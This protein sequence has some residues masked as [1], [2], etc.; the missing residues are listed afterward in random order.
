MNFPEERAVVSPLS[1]LPLIENFIMMNTTKKRQSSSTASL[2]LEALEDRMMLSSVEIFAAGET[3]NEAFNLL[4]DGN[5]VQTFDSVGGNFEAR[6]FERFVFNAD[7][8]VTA[9]RVEIEFINDQFNRNTG[10]DNNLFVDRIVVDGQTFEAEDSETFHTGLID[11]GRFVG[12]GFLQSEVLN[13]NGRISFLANQTRSFGTR[14]RVDA[15]GDT[16]EEI[17]Q[18]QIDGRAVADFNFAAAG[19]EQVLLF[20]TDEIV[21]ISRV[22]LV[23]TND[24]FDPRTGLDRNVGVRQFQTIDIQSGAR[25]IFNTTD[26]RVFASESFT[27][28]DGSVAGFGRGGFLV[29][30]GSFIEV[31]DTQQTRIR[32]DAQGQTG[33]EILQIV[34][35]GE[36]LGQFQ[37]STDR[38]TF[39]I[40][41][42][43]VVKLEDLQIRFVNDFFDPQ[44]G[45]DNNL[46][47]FNFQT[48]ELPS[49]QR[50]IAGTQE[51]N[52]FGSGVFS[53]SEGVV[54]GF[55]RGQTLVTNGFFE[56]RPDAV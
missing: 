31:R 50:A 26:G 27:D 3:G 42:P 35:N 9:D 6:Q 8:P 38:Q 39:F 21:D 1:F 54:D 25:N 15:T 23:F 37:A 52:V 22:R 32:V 45:F 12:P 51:R 14:I 48:I 16:G 40:E 56:F 4:L 41:S 18:L 34:Q 47:V 46:T 36:V 29:N 13:V 43:D 17:L 5:V 7:G 2:Q 53:T 49:G 24:A 19:Q 44:T 55:G 28:L 11:N 33:E 30:G 10:R 20:E